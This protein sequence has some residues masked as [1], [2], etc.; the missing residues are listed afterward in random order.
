MYPITPATSA[1]HYLSEVFEKVGGM[2][3]QA[4]DE[5]AACAFA[6]GASYAGKCAVTITSGPGY[7]LKQEGIGL[8]VMAEVPMVVVNVQRG[9]PST[10]QPT[11]AEQGDLLSVMFGS[12]GDA[13]KVVLAPSS[14]EDCFYSSHRLTIAETFKHGGGG[15]IGRQPRHREHP[16]ARRSSSRTGLGPPWPRA[17]CPPSRAP[18]TEA[19]TGLFRRSSGQPSACIR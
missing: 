18:T 19:A 15:A 7:S 1:S 12:H 14:I 16:F 5:I 8:A 9:G 11:K 17:R 4:E 3:H 2:V 6:L 10:G 13:P